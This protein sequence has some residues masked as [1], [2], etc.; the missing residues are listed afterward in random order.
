M[1]FNVMDHTGHSVI[2]FKPEE[3]DAA[4]AKFAELTGEGKTAASRKAG[5]SDYTVTKSFD[6][7]ADETVFITPK[8]GG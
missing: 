3:T 6:P 4:M 5:Q 8:Q 1:R 2:E 7:N